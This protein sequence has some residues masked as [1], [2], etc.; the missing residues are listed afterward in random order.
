MKTANKQKV[1]EVKKDID[2]K[3]QLREIAEEDEELLKKLE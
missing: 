2:R 1:E 3:K